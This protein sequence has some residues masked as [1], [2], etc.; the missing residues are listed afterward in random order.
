MQN[1]IVHFEIGCRDLET[2]QTF[3]GSMFDWKMQR[4]GNA[5]MIDTGSPLAA[6]SLVSGTSRITT[7][8]STCRWR[9]LGPIS[10]KPCP[11]EGNH[12]CRRSISP[13]AHLRGLRTRKETRSACSSRAREAPRV[14][15]GVPRQ[16]DLRFLPRSKSVKS[17]ILHGR[18]S[19]YGPSPS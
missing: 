12:W 9:T 19:R 18:R 1:P 17:I 7:R 10:K 16:T 5:A 2:T 11:S 13:P 3:F 6:I 15:I 8:S 14:A 4:A